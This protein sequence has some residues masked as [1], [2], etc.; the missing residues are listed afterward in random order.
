MTF[1]GPVTSETAKKVAMSF[2]LRNNPSFSGESNVV[3]I[4]H[5]EPVV[6]DYIVL[7]GSRGWVWIAGDDRV[8]PILGFGLENNFD[9]D[10]TDHYPFKSF[11]SKYR[12]QITEIIQDNNSPKNESW[13][14]L[15]EGKATKSAQSSVEPFIP[16]RFNQ[17]SG[18][19]A[20]C[21]E[22]EDGSGGHAYAGC[23][24]VSMAQAMSYYAYPSIG[25]G[26]HSYADKTYGTQIADFANTD[27]HWDLMIMTQ[28]DDYNA[29]LL[30]HCGV[31]VD[32][33]YGA[34]GS[35]AYTS[36]VAGAMRTY[37]KY[38]PSAQ[39]VK[40]SSY[41]D[42]EWFSMMRSEL[43]A[44]RPVIYSGDGDDG[45]AGHAFDLDGYKGDYFHVNWGYSGSMNGYYT[46]DNLLIN[47]NNF[48][49]NSEAVIGIIPSER[50]NDTMYPPTDITLSS[51]EVEKDLPVGSYVGKVSV[52]DKTPDDTFSYICYGAPLVAGGFKESDFYIENDSLKTKVVFDLN[53]KSQSSLT[54]QVAD[55]GG[56][57]F[58]KAF[59]IKVV[60]GSDVE[61]FVLDE[62]LKVF[63][64]P[65]DGGFYVV[66]NGEENRILKLF[67]VVGQ[68]VLEKQ[69]QPGRNVVD[70][71]KEPK[72]LYFLKVE[73][74][75]FG[76]IK[77]IKR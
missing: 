67:N 50:F 5:G 34:D 22:D 17:S 51:M 40:R 72:G 58:Q 35:G 4:P 8:E 19:N 46:L 63:P 11:F 41:S 70:I 54:I 74:E 37:F 13:S 6:T 45:E 3:V 18:W 55:N 31:S 61:K 12:K 9:M 71:K 64:N 52:T 1:A 10:M 36:N 43:D 75:P 53:K 48:S 57:T 60:V 28:A 56:N 47:D 32:M 76:S 30:Y 69:I 39:Y 16:A 25:D 23:V 20:F 68:V 21:P 33:S 62:R 73:N 26:Y 59:I 49:F 15:L 2:L 44:T 42:E 27:Y 77:L 24:A 29:L 66:Y 65:S 14:L 38:A 7:I